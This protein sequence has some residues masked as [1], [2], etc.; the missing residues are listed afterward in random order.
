ML[1][2]SAAP[3]T[4]STSSTLNVQSIQLPNSPQITRTHSLDLMAERNAMT[5]SPAS[6]Q[7]DRYGSQPRIAPDSKDE[8]PL[9]ESRSKSSRDESI[10]LTS[11]RPSKH[12]KS[13]KTSSRTKSVEVI[14]WSDDEKE[15][16]DQ[17][18]SD[19]DRE[20]EQSK[21]VKAAYQKEMSQKSQSQKHRSPC[22]STTYS[23]S[24]TPAPPRSS[25]KKSMGYSHVGQQYGV[26]D[27]QMQPAAYSQNLY[28]QQQQQQQ[29]QQQR[30]AEVMAYYQQMQNQRMMA[31]YQQMQSQRQMMQMNSTAVSNTG[32]NAPNPPALE[33]PMSRREKRKNKAVLKRL[34]LIKFDDDHKSAS[35]VSSPRSRNDRGD[36]SKRSSSKRSSSK[37]S[38]A[39]RSE[40]IMNIFMKSDEER[41]EYVDRV[42]NES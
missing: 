41:E 23:P 40:V 8:C 5:N 30:N 28:S 27:Q 7:V 2:A 26:Y 33:R 36:S 21:M 12:R 16:A 39:R 31:Y 35:P 11:V 13:K 10:P 6:P 38:A 34:N 1:P 42:I 14:R 15:L 20:R 19:V 37:R 3:L 9:K 25:S 32:T 17:I 18:V 22:N 24:P 29:Q 4:K